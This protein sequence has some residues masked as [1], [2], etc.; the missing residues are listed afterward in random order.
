M[1][2]TQYEHLHKHYLWIQDQLR[3]VGERLDGMDAALQ[4]LAQLEI[5]TSLKEMH[6]M[7][8][9][10]DEINQLGGKFDALAA[11][12]TTIHADFETLLAAM[13]ADRDNLSDAG[14]AAL[15]TANTKADALAQQLQALD[16]EVEGA[17][18]PTP[19]PAPVDNPPAADSGDQ[20]VPT[21]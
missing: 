13:E 3:V 6:A 17:D 15:D 16:V 20:P 2:S 9:A 21:A 1:E 18:N 5:V 12:V 10:A 7:A 19:T 8:N 4:G 14:Q 11:V